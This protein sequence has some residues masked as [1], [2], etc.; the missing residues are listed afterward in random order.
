[1]PIV[2]PVVLQVTLLLEHV[3]I[4]LTVLVDLLR[5]VWARIVH[6]HGK[7]DCAAFF[8]AFRVD[9]NAASV[10]LDEALADDEAETCALLVD[11]C[12][13]L[14]LAKQLEQLLLLVVLDP[15]ARV[16]DADIEEF[17]A[18]VERRQDK[19]L[20]FHAELD[21]VSQQIDEDLRKSQLVS[22]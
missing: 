4:V 21:G 6:F 3:C 1:M 8:F 20:A 13:P 22:L 19:Y 9:L 14:Q 7:A 2:S 5:L 18:M 12:R 16:D 17:S 11:V 10:H 15:T